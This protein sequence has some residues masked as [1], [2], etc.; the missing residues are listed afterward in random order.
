MA[1]AF[2]MG[3]IDIFT[4][5]D[6]T[7]YMLV[8]YGKGKVMRGN[9]VYLC[10]PYRD[11][12]NDDKEI[13]VVKRIEIRNGDKWEETEE[14]ENTLVAIRVEKREKFLYL[15]GSVVCTMEATADEI[16]EI[17]AA[18]L[19]DIYVV[20]RNLDLTEADFNNLSVTELSDIMRLN[21]WY[22][23]TQVKDESEESRMENL[24]RLDAVGAELSKRLMKLDHIY[25][26]FSRRT[27]EPYLFTKFAKDENR[28]FISPPCIRLITDIYLESVEST[29]PKDQYFIKKLEA[30][31]DGKGIENFLKTAFYIEGA[32]GMEVNT[33]V[34]SVRREITGV[35][36][37]GIPGMNDNSELTSFILMMG[38]QKAPESDD[39]KM[40]SRLLYEHFA[41]LINKATLMVP[42]Q[43]ETVDGEPVAGGRVEVASIPAREEGKYAVKAYTDNWHMVMAYPGKPKYINVKLSDVIEKYDVVINVAPISMGYTY[44]DQKAFELI[45]SVNEVLGE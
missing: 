23:S 33:N 16:R 38:Q 35:T 19:G 17:H 15:K 31:E 44:V 2:I 24:Q 43:I 21:V 28:Y 11:K 25:C 8:G 41:K 7:D 29:Y 22:H 45:K 5:Q 4:I 36:N 39:E 27:G 40:L 34:F 20:K 3:V 14:A 37:P 42:A 9:A 6:S 13:A 12:I 1:A 32:K 30:G 10:N 26:I 18:T